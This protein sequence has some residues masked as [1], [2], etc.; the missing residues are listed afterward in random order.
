MSVLFDSNVLIDDLDLHYPDA[1][2]VSILTMMELAAGV[3][4]ATTVKERVKREQ[5][6]ERCRAT[7]DPYLVNLPVLES[8]HAIE[9]AMRAQARTAK[10]R[11]IDLILAATALTHGL[12]LVTSNLDDFAGLDDVVKVV[13][14]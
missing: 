10:S 9:R 1:G 4:T 8:Y 14:P 7:Y 3:Y 12:T 13:A 11:R 2:G 5:R 6:Y